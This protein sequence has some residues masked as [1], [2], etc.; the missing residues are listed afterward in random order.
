MILSVLTLLGALGMFLYGMNT[1][2]DG[3]EK[4]SGGKLEKT[5]EKI[6]FCKQADWIKKKTQSLPD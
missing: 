6:A 1:M 5:L 2:G 3:L 4:F